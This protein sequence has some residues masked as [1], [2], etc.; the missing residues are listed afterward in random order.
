MRI[1]AYNQ[2]TQI[3]QSSNLKKTQDKKTTTTSFRDQLMLSQTAKDSQT[4][5]KALANVSDVRQELTAPIKEAI[6]NG[7]YEVDLDDFAGKL[8]EKYGGLF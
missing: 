4:A 5:K 2:I 3:Y 7:T 1:D 6:D 8:L